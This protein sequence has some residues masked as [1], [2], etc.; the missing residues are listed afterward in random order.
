MPTQDSYLQTNF[1]F[2]SPYNKSSLRTSARASPTFTLRFT[3]DY[4]ALRVLLALTMP[5]KGKARAPV[6]HR[7][8]FECVYQLLTFFQITPKGKGKGK[9][10]AVDV[11]GYHLRLPFF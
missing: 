10:P 9:R 6:A 3:F 11:V 2:F 5:P 8:R 4:P 1:S 7:L